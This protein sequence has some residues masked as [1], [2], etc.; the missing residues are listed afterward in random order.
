LKMASNFI[1]GQGLSVNCSRANNLAKSD[2]IVIYLPC[3]KLQHFFCKKVTW[4]QTANQNATFSVVQ[5]YTE[6]SLSCQFIISFNVMSSFQD[7]L[8]VC[9][10]GCAGATTV[11]TVPTRTTTNNNSNGPTEKVSTLLPVL[12]AGNSLFLGITL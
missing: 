2:D 10:A 1:I 8:T 4:L 9:D 5:F 11:R 6:F 3:L 12:H 7:H